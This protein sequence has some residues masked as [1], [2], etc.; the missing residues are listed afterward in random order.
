VLSATGTTLV[1]RDQRTLPDGTALSYSYDDL[2]SL[3]EIKDATAGTSQAKYYYDAVGRRMRKE[4][5][6][7]AFTTYQY[8]ALNRLTN[9]VNS[10]ATSN[11]IS[12]FSILYDPVGNI[13]FKDTIEGLEFYQYDALNQLTNVI[14]P[15]GVTNGFLY[16]A[17]GNRTAV[18]SNGVAVSYGVNRLNQYTNVGGAVLSYDSNGNLVAKAENG[19]TTSYEYDCENRLVSVSTPTNSIR[20]RYDP[21]GQRICT[22]NATGSVYCY[23]DRLQVALETDAA[24][25]PQATYVWGDNIDE[26]VRMKRGGIRYF[27]AKTR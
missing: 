4:L 24:G 27:Y 23:Y 19:Q 16:D 13:L 8:D 15:N 9:L 11:I 26:V 6:N 18:L 7:G 25:T 22:S 1:Q 10:S 20:Y 2:G 12:R 5:G 17:M 14:Y 21:F 3:S